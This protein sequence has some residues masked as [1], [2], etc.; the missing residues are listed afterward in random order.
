MNKLYYKYKLT[1][2]DHW[3]K[4][5][6]SKI[7]FLT[8]YNNDLE[9]LFTSLYPNYPW[10][11]SD[12]KYYFNSIA[13]QRKKMDEIFKNLN[14]NSIDDL[15]DIN[16]EKFNKNGG[17]KLLLYYNNDYK[18]LLKTIYPNH[19]WCFKDVMKDQM[20]ENQRRRMEK[21]YYKLKYKNFDDWMNISRF[22]LITNGGTLLYKLYNG[23]IKL[24]L[25]SIYPNYPWNFSIM[26]ISTNIY[27][28][29]I[30]N[31]RLF[32]GKL[33]RK[34]KL[35]KI[36]DFK[37]ISKRKFQINGGQS[38]YETYYRGDLLSLLSSIYPNYPWYIIEDEI[39]NI[40][41]NVKDI[42]VQQNFM[43]NLFYQFKLID[44]GDWIY[45][46]Q[47]N[48]KLYGGKNLLEEYDYNMKILLITIYP[49]YPWPFLKTKNISMKNFFKSIDNQRQFMSK[50]YKKFRLKSLEDWKKIKKK[51]IILAGGKS[52][53]S[54]YKFS[55]PNLLISIYPNYPWIFEPPKIQNVVKYFQSFENQQ[56]YMEQLFITL[57]LK[58]LDDWL[59]ISN[60]IIKKNRGMQLLRIYKRM[61]ILLR[62]IYPNYPW[63]LT[64]LANKLKKTNQ[65]IILNHR[66][67]ID[68]LFIKFKFNELSDWL[69]IKRN[70]IWNDGGGRILKRYN[71]DLKLILLTFY[72][73]YPWD[74]INNHGSIKIKI[75]QWIINYL[76]TKKSDWYRIP[77]LHTK[78]YSRLKQFYH[79]ERWEKNLFFSRKK[80]AQR[81][82]FINTQKIYPTLLII[83]DYFHPKLICDNNLQLDIFI[84]ALQ[85]ALEYQGEQ[86]YDDL[87]AAFGG[88]TIDLSIERDELKENLARENSINIIYIPYWW[89]KSLSSLKSSLQS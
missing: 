14:L 20:I 44:L 79:D 24:F 36:S 78:V 42:K 18:K 15:S 65:T 34:L 16:H 31:Q 3:L 41:F 70:I 73:N 69:R 23:D 17:K 60:E 25:Q 43:E 2:L 32:M 64:F 48:I 4:I 45:F 6:I 51:D 77:E 39:E 26:R 28:K 9:I 30:E 29:S 33:Y 89:D 38:L 80:L 19:T 40:I 71:K 86:H 13:N 63:K 81:V 35:K 27:F 50:L 83:E 52:I 22:K 21:L 72:P 55:Y 54:I 58:T 85:L 56:E 37:K 76:I 74:F 8:D 11:F 84:P 59:N 75:K 87:P 62:T 53:V 47:Y 10:D 68:N 49:N 57:N 5:S 1:N 46:S 61:K 88:N 12:T 7:P 67:I 82:L 66:R